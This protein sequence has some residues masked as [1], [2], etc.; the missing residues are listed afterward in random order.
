ME[1]SEKKWLKMSKSENTF[2]INTKTTKKEEK[3]LHK[4][5]RY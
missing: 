5:G 4:E 3:C 2:E 1:K